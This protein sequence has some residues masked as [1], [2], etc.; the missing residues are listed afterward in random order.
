[1]VGLGCDTERLVI[2]TVLEGGLERLARV[3]LLSLL[4]KFAVV[5]TVGGVG[6]FQALDSGFIAVDDTLEDTR[7]AR[8]LQVSGIDII[9]I[10]DVFSMKEKRLMVNQVVSR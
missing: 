10:N 3:I 7:G 4:R 5:V 8:A 6:L 9:S 2:A 1:V